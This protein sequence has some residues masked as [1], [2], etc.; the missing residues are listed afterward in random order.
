MSLL[1]DTNALL[2]RQMTGGKTLA[3]IHRQIGGEDFSREWFYKFAAGDIAD[4]GVN[5][6]QTLH[7][8]LARLE[9]QS[10]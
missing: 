6:I 5:R 1:R 8:R 3:E 10:S 7:D 4:P 9:S 2:N